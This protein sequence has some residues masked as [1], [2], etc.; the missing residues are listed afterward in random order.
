LKFRGSRDGWTAEIIHA[1]IDNQGPTITIIKTLKGKIFGGFSS[2]SWDTSEVDKEDKNAFLFSVDLGIKNPVNLS[3]SYKPIKCSK[4]N[5][6][7]F[8]G[9][10]VFYVPPNANTVSG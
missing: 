9:N 4:S 6:P 3:S 1:R 8:G 7:Y 2:V 10:W 5:G